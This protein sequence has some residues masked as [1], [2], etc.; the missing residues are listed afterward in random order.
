M[1]LVMATTKTTY[2]AF[3]ILTKRMNI[4][5]MFEYK[6]FVHNKIIPFFKQEFVPKSRLFFWKLYLNDDFISDAYH[7]NKKCFTYISNIY[8]WY[9]KLITVTSDKCEHPMCRTIRYVQYI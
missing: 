2:I 3:P 7:K 5:F 1:H 9:L 4:R 6:P 8:F